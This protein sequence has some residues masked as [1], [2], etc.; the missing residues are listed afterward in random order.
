MANRASNPQVK[1]SPMQ[2]S[3]HDNDLSQIAPFE[4]QTRNDQE[5]FIESIADQ[6]SQQLDH[7]I[8]LTDKRTEDA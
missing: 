4:L 6:S 2:K 8:S 7:T 1:K 3:D 5:R